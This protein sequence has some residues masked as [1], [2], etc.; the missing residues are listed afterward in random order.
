MG[1]I[2]SGTGWGRTAVGES[3]NGT[4]YR[5]TGWGRTAIGEYDNGTIYKGTGWGRTAIGEYDN[6]TTYEG[7]GWGRTA[8]G[9][10]DEIFS[11]A[12]LLLFSFDGTRNVSVSSNSSEDSGFIEV[13]LGIIMIIGMALFKIVKFLY[14]YFFIPYA[15]AIPWYAIIM[16]L[17]AFV[18][19]PQVVL[20]VMLITF[21]I[22]FIPYFV[23]LIYRKIKGQISLDEMFVYYAM[24]WLKGPYIYYEMYKKKTPEPIAIKHIFIKWFIG[25]IAIIALEIVFKKL[26]KM[27]KIK[28]REEQTNQIKE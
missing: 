10:C 24:W 12:A 6:G 2:Y 28:K 1:S 7:T 22:S 9:E 18:G 27:Y 23:I 8:V 26:R 5:G 11:A 3:D 25:G 4:I 14:I 15:S 16:S 20:S 13:L 21:I 19:F 17:L